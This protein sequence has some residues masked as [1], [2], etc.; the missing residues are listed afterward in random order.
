MRVLLCGCR[1]APA[2]NWQQATVQD[3][4]LSCWCFPAAAGMLLCRA[5]D[6]AA[7]DALWMTVIGVGRQ[8]PIVLIA[9]P[10]VLPHGYCVCVPVVDICIMALPMDG[11]NQVFAHFGR[12]AG[13]F[14]S[15]SALFLFF[16]VVYRQSVIVARVCVPTV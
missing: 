9:Q 6:T 14:C 15:K 7:V 12:C 13:R 16:W 8:S 2:A 1:C 11:A 5:D 3:W 10:A 4:Q